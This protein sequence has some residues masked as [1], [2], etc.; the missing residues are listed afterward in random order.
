ME[1]SLQNDFNKALSFRYTCFDRCI[2]RGY[3]HQLFPIGGVVNYYRSLNINNLDKDTLKI[4]TNELVAHIEKYAMQ[5]NIPIEWWSSVDW[6]D[7]T[8]GGKSAYV[9]NKY[10]KQYTGFD[11]KIFTIISALEKTYTIENSRKKSSKTLYRVKKQVKFYYI[12]FYDKV[13]GGLCY[14]KI[15]TYVPFE[16][17]FYCNGHHFI[18]HNL[19]KEGISYKQEGNCF[20]DCQKPE[21]LQELG[22]HITVA[23]VLERCEYWKQQFFKFNKGSYS[24]TNTDLQHQWYSSQIEVCTNLIFKEKTF[25]RDFFN[26][27][28]LL[29]SVLQLSDVLT[30]VFSARPRN[31][32]SKTTQ[33]T[34]DLNAVIKHWFRGNSIKMYNKTGTLIRIETTINHPAKPGGT[35]LKKGILYLQSLFWRAMECNERYFEYCNQINFNTVSSEQ[36]DNLK[37]TI[38]KSNGKNVASPDLRKERQLEL[39]SVLLRPK[40][41]VAPFGLK[42]L[43]C[44]LSSYFTKSNQIRYEIEKLLV[45]GLVEK[46]QSSNYYVVTQDGFA[47]IW[48]LI[49]TYKHFHNPLLSRSYKTE[50]SKLTGK[51]LKFEQGYDDIKQGLKSIF[52]ALSMQKTA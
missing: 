17:E 1:Q 48:S 49:M 24:K 52:I 47:Q 12:Y 41:I 22:K 14:L 38:T 9:E 3:L 44:Y 15:C 4:P 11:N 33:R 16:M 5:N 20:T 8:N 13:L 2:F 37:Q 51:T 18:A 26:K 21:R 19:R 39:L 25:G 34:Y 29:F 42:E 32:Q 28:I 30:K 27:M 45:R 50:Y 6:N 43:K 46:M 40:F 10:L 31:Y 23:D 7:K 36:L 35:R